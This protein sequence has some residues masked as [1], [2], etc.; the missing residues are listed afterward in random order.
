[1]LSHLHFYRDLTHVGAD[2]THQKAYQDVHQDQTV[3]LGPS[4]PRKAE[5][6]YAKATPHFKVLPS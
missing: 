4:L 5:V 6:P 1:M 2:W 3:R